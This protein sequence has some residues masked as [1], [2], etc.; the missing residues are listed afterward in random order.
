MV[1]GSLWTPIPLP[2]T[3][4]STKKVPPGPWGMLTVCPPSRLQGPC[5]EMNHNFVCSRVPIEAGVVRRPCEL[6]VL[7]AA[8][9]SSSLTTGLSIN[10]S[11]ASDKRPRKPVVQ[12]LVSADMG[13]IS[14]QTSEV[15]HVWGWTLVTL[16]VI[17]QLAEEVFLL[18]VTS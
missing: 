1:L 12:A 10:R 9:E 2:G 7:R 14:Y 6:Q 17:S 8:L 18:G 3:M 16:W 15:E 5:L 13:L 4:A 11:E